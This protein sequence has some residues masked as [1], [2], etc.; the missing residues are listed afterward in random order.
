M[1][2]S[3][4]LLLILL[5]VISIP[6]HAID[7]PTIKSFTPES[8]VAKYNPETLY[9]YIN[10]G[11]DV[12]LSFGFKELLTKDF[13]YQEL[14]FSVDIYDM[15]SRVNGF[16]IYKVE[17]PVDANFLK[18]GV[19]AVVSPPYQCLLLK[20]S[21]YVKI[22]I[23]EGEFR[24]E[25]GKDILRKVSAA[26]PGSD[27]QPTE[28]SVLPVKNKIAYSEG[29]SREAFLGIDLLE[30]CVY[31]KYKKDSASFRYFS[32][33][34]IKEE[35]SKIT[36]QKISEK[37]KHAEAGKSTVLYKKIPY[38]GYTGIILSGDKILGVADC[39]NLEQVLDLL[40]VIVK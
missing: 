7:F 8:E 4:S 39:K 2:N 24:Q 16:G 1:K 3:I 17:R 28:F 34:S 31:A 37:W 19:E 23:F 27:K 32:I 22:N 35:P 26:L 9:E 13:S 33:V 38:K 5:I 14:Q 15:G 11:A 18:I 36:W 30:R 40:N 10:G 12:F 21:Y 25:S 6:A 20:D 29:Y